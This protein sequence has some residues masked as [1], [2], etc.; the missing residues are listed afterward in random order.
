MSS[1]MFV[2]PLYEGSRVITLP[3]NGHDV[4]KSI[5]MD[6]IIESSGGRLMTSPSQLL[7][8]VENG[9]RFVNDRK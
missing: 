3:M 7:K 5:L 8:L 6:F 4:M 1:Y 2:Y 9:L